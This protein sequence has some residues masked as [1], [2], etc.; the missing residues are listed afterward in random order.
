[1]PGPAWL[2]LLSVSARRAYPFV[3]A[4][5]EGGVSSRALTEILREGGTPLRR[6][7]LLEMMRRISG[8]EASAKRIRNVR[9]DRLPTAGTLPEALTKIKKRYSFRVRV[10][11]V[12]SSTG[13]RVK[14]FINVVS[15]ELMTPHQAEMTAEE[16]ASTGTSWDVIEIESSTLVSA[17]KSGV[18]GVL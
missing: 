17:V 7:S 18:R 12:W 2:S 3:L 10:E 16:Y 9:K 4:G 8:V 15:N 1:M 6:Q 11:G 5:V 14:Q 13:E